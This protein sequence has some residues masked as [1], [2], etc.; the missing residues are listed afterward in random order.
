MSGVEPVKGLL[1]PTEDSGVSA[2][3]VTVVVVDDVV[4]SAETLAAMLRPDGY[5][6]F[7]ALGAEEALRLIDRERPHCVLYDVVMPGIGGDAL[8][9]RLRERYGDDIVLIAMTGHDED[10]AR[11]ARTFSLADHYLRKPVHPDSLRKV[12]PPVR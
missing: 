10:D 1:Q 11:V 3:I 7:T 2:D 4:D 12:L 5:T 8:S 6:V 9:V